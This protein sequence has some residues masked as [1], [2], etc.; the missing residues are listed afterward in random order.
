MF[1]GFP[2]APT[3]ARTTRTTHSA[4]PLLLVTVFNGVLFSGAGA[5]GTTLL[6]GVVAVAW[7][8]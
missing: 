6:L 4:R 8:V 7:L 3:S 1:V 2:F 5:G